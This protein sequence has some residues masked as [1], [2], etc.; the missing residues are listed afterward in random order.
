MQHGFRKRHSCKS[1]SYTLLDLVPYF[2][3]K[4]TIDGVILDPRKA[5]DTVPHNK[6]LHKLTH[7]NINGDLHCSISNFNIARQQRV[8][9]NDIPALPRGPSWVQYYFYCLLTI[10]HLSSKKASRMIW[11]NYK[12]ISSATGRKKTATREITK[13][14]TC[15]LTCDISKDKHTN[16]FT[17]DIPLN[18]GHMPSGYESTWLN[19]ATS[20]LI[21]A[22]FRMTNILQ[23]I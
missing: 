8:I 15:L 14:T 3:K 6:L 2:D 20:Q 13:R 1:Q 12:R 18:L 21:F 23:F 10:C 11:N 22:S 9:A 19:L 4:I 17:G 16:N 5:F 7:Y